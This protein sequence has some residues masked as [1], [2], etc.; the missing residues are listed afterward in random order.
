MSKRAPRLTPE[1]I[2]SQFAAGAPIGTECT[3]YP[4]KPF[5]REEAFKTK[6]RSEPW[7]LGHG[8]VVVAVEGKT[9][10]VSIEHITFETRPAGG[11]TEDSELIADLES[12]RADV[13]W[14]VALCAKAAKR[15]RELTGS[16]ESSAPSIARSD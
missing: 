9:G 7:V 12:N 3:Y 5:R 2:A 14:R 8:A 6:I 13:T 15:L 1:L 10:G 11:A 16:A 4:I